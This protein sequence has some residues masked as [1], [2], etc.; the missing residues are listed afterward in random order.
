MCLHSYHILLNLAMIYFASFFVS[1]Y[2]SVEKMEMAADADLKMD[3][4]DQM[5]NSSEHVCSSFS[6]LL[7]NIYIYFLLILI[8][9]LL[10][11]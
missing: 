6:N 5:P 10:F 1:D 11:W 2:F 3:D 8:L 4:D 7:E 9:S